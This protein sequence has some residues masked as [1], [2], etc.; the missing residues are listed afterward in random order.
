MKSCITV[1]QMN[2]RDIPHAIASLIAEIRQGRVYSNK[3]SSFLQE[4]C[5][6]RP[7]A[8]GDRLPVGPLLC[9]LSSMMFAELFGLE[10]QFLSCDAKSELNA[11]NFYL[12][13][14]N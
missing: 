5:S 12:L 8:G 3:A 7:Q 6:A 13:T 14:P 11:T 10:E 2:R 9:G 1:D 4:D